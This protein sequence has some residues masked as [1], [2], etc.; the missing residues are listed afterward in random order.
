ML[1]MPETRDSGQTKKT[2]DKCLP[3]H[4]PAAT[5]NKRPVLEY[6]LTINKR[7][8]GTLLTVCRPM[9]KQLK[10]IDRESIRVFIPNH[11]HSLGKIRATLKKKPIPTCT[12]YT[13]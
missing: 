7:D 2:H 8:Q 5:G 3:G 4:T 9:L 11:N 1:K 12:K 13:V 6:R 10:T